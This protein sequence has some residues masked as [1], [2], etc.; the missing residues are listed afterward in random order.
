MLTAN[1]KNGKRINLITIS[2]LDKKALIKEK[3]T[4]C[5]CRQAVR[6]RFGEIY[7]AHF[8]HVQLKDC[9][10]S[11]ENESDEHIGLKSELYHSLVKQDQVIIEAV[12]PKL[13]QIA[14]LLVNQSLAL[15]IQCSPLSQKRLRQRTVSY[16]KNNFTVLWL[17]GQKLWLKDRINSLQ[18]QFLYFSNNIGFHLWEL[19]LK[20]KCLRLKYLIYEDLKG[21]L[22]Y[23][24]K[25]CSFT[26]DLLTFL[27]FPFQQQ[28]M[29]SYQVK[30]AEDLIFYIQKQ[31]YYKSPKWLKKQEVAYQNGDNLLL[32]DLD[33]FFPQVRPLTCDK[34]FVQVVYDLSAYYSAFESYYQKIANK[35]HQTLY[36]PKFYDTIQ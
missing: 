15:E 30:M 5:A 36:P 26:G 10:F 16:Q 14:D 18:K 9:L 28:K 35:S 34:G 25:T 29:S 20:Q 12:L 23:L 22:H 33:E 24:E 6:L 32:K 3:F 19:D 8:A 31:L 13:N 21:T 27:R 4:C 1:D 2:Y 17:L 11:Y 7:K